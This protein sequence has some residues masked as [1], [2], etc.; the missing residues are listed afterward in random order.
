MLRIVKIL[1]I[2]AVAAWG[3]VGAFL[4]LVN[5]EG[6]LASVAAATSMSTFEGGADSWQATSNA[7]LMWLGAIFI[8]ASKVTAAV[9][10]LVGASRMWQARAADARAF[11]TAKEFAMVGCGIAVFMLFAGFIVVAESWFEMWRS[12]FL[13]AASLESAFRYAG[14]IALIALFVAMP[15]ES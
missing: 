12:E 5:W 6:T 9:F 7:L 2:L 15:E 14:M 11:R 10:C 13:R 3:A 4:N 1:L 8:A